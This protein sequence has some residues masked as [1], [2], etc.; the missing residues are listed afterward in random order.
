[1][2]VLGNSSNP[3]IAETINYSF[4]LN[5][6]QIVNF[7]PTF[8]GAPVV[9]SSGPLGTFSIGGISMQGYIAFFSP[10]MVFGSRHA[11]MDLMGFFSPVIPPLHSPAPIP[12]QGY[13]GSWLYSCTS[14]STGPC[15]PFYTGGD[16]Y[17]TNTVS[18]HQV[19]EP[20]TLCVLM[21]GALAL[22]LMKK[23][24]TN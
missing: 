16:I 10:V 19:P 22:C 4:E 1:M 2:T 15:A 24:L 13:G 20:G 5:Y 12:G 23:A 6:S 17:G 9:T 8:V 3:G 18:V 14:L 11:E 7:V 21:L